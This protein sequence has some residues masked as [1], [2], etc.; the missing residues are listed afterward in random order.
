MQPIIEIRNIGKKYD[1]NH[2]R[3]GY[4]AL[5]DVLTVILKSPLRFLKQKAKDAVGIGT[6]EEF[7]AL[8]DVSLSINQGEVIGV[9]GRNGAGKST[10]L[11]IL[12]GI[13]PP[14]EGEIVMRGKVAS[15]LEV[16]TGFHPELTGRENIFLNG[17]I[18][19][20]TKKEIVSKF[21]EIVI[22]ANIE[23]FL[24]TP[25][26]Y[27]SSG[28]YVR[29]A[30]AVA[31]HME[32]DILLVDEVL[33]VGDAEFQKKCLGKMEEVAHGKGRTILFVS[34]NMNAIERLCSKTALLKNG[35]II[36]FGETSEVIN[37]YLNVDRSLNS[38]TEYSIKKELDGQITKV[39]ILN[40]DYQ[41]E[42]QIPIGEKFFIEIE[43]D[44][45]KR[46]ENKLLILHFYHHGELLLVSTEGDL[47]GKHRDYEIG[48]Y[49]TRVEI[50]GSL[51]QVGD[52][53]AII[54][55]K[56]ISERK[57]CIDITK[58]INIEI[59]SK[60]NPRYSIFGD[61]YWGKISSIL[62]YKTEKII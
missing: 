19:G 60:N 31:A 43:L 54:S 12:T 38:I 57:S 48:K 53:S 62:N 49:K 29:L 47:G 27:Y 35:R 24:D 34:H 56:H 11:K 15:L 59:T 36:K 39:S 44:V 4:V 16:G 61:N 50:P 18:L 10:L 7:W 6:K 58:D 55:F 20:M 32:P 30:F 14:T 51:F 13:T 26:K 3:G 52:L 2:Q 23:K 40:K 21:N 42:F 8:K 46:L 22:F 41:P 1:I 9:I 25:V 17:A 33:A 37:Y 28:M 45:R 5:R